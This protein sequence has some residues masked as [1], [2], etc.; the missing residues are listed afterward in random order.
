MTRW[1]VAAWC[2]ELCCC[3]LAACG[4]PGEFGVS[5]NYDMNPTP[6]VVSVNQSTWFSFGYAW[7]SVSTTGAATVSVTG[8]HLTIR[9]GLSRILRRYCVARPK[10]LYPEL[11]RRESG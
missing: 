7:M 4:T 3:L 10:V 11:N 6:P 5:V 8:Y 2:I 1:R 9:G